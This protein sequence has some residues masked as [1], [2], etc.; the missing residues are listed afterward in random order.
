MKLLQKCIINSLNQN[1]SDA[2]LSLGEMKG[3]NIF[4]KN[5]IKVNFKKK[6]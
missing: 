6:D 5:F 3:I 4:S 1:L 2:N